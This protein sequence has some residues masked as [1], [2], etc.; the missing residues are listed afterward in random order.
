MKML[1]PDVPRMR[2]TPPFEPTGEIKDQHVPWHDDFC[3]NC[4]ADLRI[5]R[6]LVNT[7]TLQDSER[8]VLCEPAERASHGERADKPR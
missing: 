4:G 1:I 8:L 7:V 2:E 5:P 6:V 3:L